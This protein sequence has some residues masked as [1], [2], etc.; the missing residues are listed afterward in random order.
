[1]DYDRILKWNDDGMMCATCVGC[2]ENDICRVWLD[3]LGMYETKICSC[4][5]NDDQ[6]CGLIKEAESGGHLWVRENTL[7][8]CNLPNCWSTGVANGYHCSLHEYHKSCETSCKEHEGAICTPYRGT[9][10][11]K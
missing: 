10:P 11:R 8:G 2:G 9:K 6:L 3:E 1:M 5:A 7:F 4:Y